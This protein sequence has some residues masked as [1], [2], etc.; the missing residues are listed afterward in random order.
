M[1]IMTLNL[2]MK[3]ITRMVK[4]D[5]AKYILL[6]VISITKTPKTLI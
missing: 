1:I 4:R 5:L 3:A 6:K 2:L